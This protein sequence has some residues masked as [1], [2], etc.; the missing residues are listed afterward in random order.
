LDRIGCRFQRDA[1]CGHDFAVDNGRGDGD[2]TPEI[3][4]DRGGLGPASPMKDT[5]RPLSIRLV[6]VAE[7]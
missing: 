1:R 6:A 4:C 7:V 3:I 2:S 5:G